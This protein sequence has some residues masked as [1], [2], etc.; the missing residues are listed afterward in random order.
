MPNSMAPTVT[1]TSSQLSLSQHA[2]LKQRERGTGGSSSSGIANNAA[3][4]AAA[5]IAAARAGRKNQMDEQ[6]HRHQTQNPQRGV[7]VPSSEARQFHDTLNQTIMKTPQSYAEWREKTLQR[8]HVSNLI[9]PKV[10]ES[11]R[12]VE[13]VTLDRRFS[14]KPQPGQI[15]YS[16]SMTNWMGLGHSQE[17][18]EQFARINKSDSDL[19]VVTSPGGFRGDGL[20]SGCLTPVR[21]ITE[22]YRSAETRLQKMI[23]NNE[24]KSHRSE[25]PGGYAHK[26]L[27]ED[28]L[29]QMSEYSIPATVQRLPINN[30][31]KEKLAHCADK[32]RGFG[33]RKL[34]EQEIARWRQLVRTDAQLQSRIVDALSVDELKAL[35]EL[36][37][38]RLYF[39]RTKWTQIMECVG[40]FVFTEGN[41]LINRPAHTQHYRDQLL[42]MP[43]K[44][45][46]D[47]QVPPVANQLSLRLNLFKNLGTNVNSGTAKQKSAGRDRSPIVEN[48]STNTNRSTEAGQKKKKKQQKVVNASREREPESRDNTLNVYAEARG[49]REASEQSRASKW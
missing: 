4:A 19:A 40:E 38:Y 14:N 45:L 23:H 33:P 27:D 2:L 35:C 43:R 32:I 42:L 15:A 28:E 36:P 9:L 21:S 3:L 26:V 13:D 34:T 46:N 22:I 41:L 8:H 17:E 7:D 30:E 48:S 31:I 24:D 39:T 20:A 12:P 5:T 1:A 49:K 29:V 11:D 44:T 10:E 47:I 18:H 16:T 6:R 37:D 25:G